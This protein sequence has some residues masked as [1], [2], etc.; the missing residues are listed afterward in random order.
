MADGRRDL[1]E[2]RVVVC[3]DCDLV[4]RRI[5]L[6][7][8]I[9]ACCPR[10]GAL[11]QRRRSMGLQARCAL[12]LAGLLVFFLANGFPLVSMRAQGA[13][14]TTTLAGTVQ[15]LWLQGMLP[16]AVLVAVTAMLVP[17]LEL[18]VLAYLLFPLLWGRAPS[19]YQRVLRLLHVL[20]PWGMAEVF[21]IGVLVALAK[22]AHLAE[23]SVGPGL[24]AFCALIL[25]LALNASQF[26]AQGLWA[27]YRRLK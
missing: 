2:D 10:C 24:W 20:H 27:C 4:Q 19:G 23:I 15:A 14:T 3:P 17:L 21:L 25:L 7:H 11:L 13:Q 16:V 22:L 8:S 12:V 26:D 9:Q 5:A 6:G 1:P 18:L